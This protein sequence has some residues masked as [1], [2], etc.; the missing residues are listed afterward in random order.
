VQAIDRS[1]RFARG[2]LL[3]FGPRAV[4][5]S[6][7]EREY[8]T[9]KWDFADHTEGDPVYVYLERY[10]KSGC[11]LDVGCG[12]GNTSNEIADSAYSSYLGVD[13]SSEALAKAARRS[14]MNGRAGKNRFQ[15]SDFM[16][17]H[18][19]E[20][21]NVVLFR[22]SMYHVPIGK[23]PPLLAKYSQYLKDDGVFIVRLCTRENGTVKHR[24]MKMIES[25]VE[26]F[27]ILERSTSGERGVAVIVF[28][29][30]QSASLRDGKR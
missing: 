6:F 27:E 20:R 18:T 7:W 26:N 17:F 8:K 1:L 2:F 28:R 22:E 5:R 4:K 29:P 24:P 10:A 19:L 30:R 3:S 9:T 13:I 25:I 11:I 15:Q 21:F 12:S 23:I 16:N 14:E